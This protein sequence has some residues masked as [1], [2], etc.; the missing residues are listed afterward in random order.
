M[1]K[2]KCVDHLLQNQREG[3]NADYQIP[4][5]HTKS[6]CGDRERGGSIAGNLQT[7]QVIRMY[8]EV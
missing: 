6:E 8:N 1:L 3:K 2:R 4:L 5:S 7:H